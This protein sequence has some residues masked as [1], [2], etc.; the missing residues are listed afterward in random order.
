MS[1]IE[2]SFPGVQALK[3]AGIA[4]RHGEV[5][6]LIGENGAEKSTL[7]KILGGAY[8]PDAGRIMIEGVA[9]SIRSP[10]DSRDAGV[11]IIYQEFQSLWMPVSNSNFQ[12]P[13]KLHISK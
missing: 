4:L 3:N 2:K 8:L 5:L 11:A 1:G 7:M 13:N 9:L 10:S 12:I 6:A